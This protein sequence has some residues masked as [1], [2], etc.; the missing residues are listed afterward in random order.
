MNWIACPVRNNLVFTRKAVKTFRNQDIDGGV[1][2]LITDN[3]STDGTAQ[4]LQAQR[5]LFVQSFQDP[6]LSVAESWNRSLHFI[7]NTMSQPYAMVVNSDVELRPDTMRHLV[8]DGGEF[9]TAVGT[10]DPTKI[11]SYT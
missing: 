4:W 2:I 6:G 1:H 5:D 10:R 11:E 8:N 9:V 7:F 3:G